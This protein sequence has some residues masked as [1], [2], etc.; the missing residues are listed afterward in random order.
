MTQ[1][2]RIKKHYSFFR[3]KKEFE[4]YSLKSAKSYE[5]L[6][7]WLHSK[8]S[9]NQF[10]LLSGILVGC[11]AGLAGVLLKSLVHYIHYVITD[12]VHFKTQLVFYMI[13]P[14]LGIVLTTLIVIWFFKGQSRKGIPAILPDHPKCGNSRTR[15]IGRT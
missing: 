15:R 13:F 4:Q 14:F 5:L 8:L 12:K 1:F 11:T 10:L 6:L 7:H 2:S 9:R 3:F